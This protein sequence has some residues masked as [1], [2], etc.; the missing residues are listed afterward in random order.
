MKKL[1]ITFLALVLVIAMILPVGVVNAD[2]PQIVVEGS[3]ELTTVA[4]NFKWVGKLDPF[5]GRV[6]MCEFTD[7][8]EYYDGSFVGTATETLDVRKNFQSGAFSSVGIQEFDGEFLGAPGK[9]TARVR[10]QGGM[11]D[12][13][14]IEMTIIS[15]E[16]ACENLHGTLIFIA[17]PIYS[18]GGIIRYEGIYSGKLH[19]APA[20]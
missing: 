10:H 12:V 9:F 14:R 1:Y 20:P 19:F 5:P 15:G 8:I 16:G 11:D 17:N 7:T 18:N 6:L 3:F 2:S 4:A 13:A